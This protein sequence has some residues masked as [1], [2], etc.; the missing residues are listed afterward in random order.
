MDRGSNKYV[1]F[2]IFA[3]ALVAVWSII[4]CADLLTWVLEAAPI[5][6]AFPIMWYTYR[7]FPLTNMLYTLIAFHSVILFIGAHYTYAQMPLFNWIR[8]TFE[9]SRNHYDRFGH[10]FQ[11]FV[12]ALVAREIFVRQNIVTSRRWL[13]FIIIAVCMGVSAGYE[14]IEWAAAEISAEASEAFLGTQGDGW[15]TQKDMAVCLLGATC[16]VFFASRIHDKAIKKISL[17]RSEMPES[18]R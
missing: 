1:S 11:G 16:A 17:E 6:I 5:L 15:D 14:L 7:R 4:D 13:V 18:V 12:P 9:L 3:V 10:F 8:D 2:L